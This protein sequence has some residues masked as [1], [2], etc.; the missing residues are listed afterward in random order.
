[1]T[2]LVGA[3]LAWRLERNNSALSL[4]EAQQGV[5]YLRSVVP[6]IVG[7]SEV[8]ARI[9]D[10][11][12]SGIAIDAPLVVNNDQ[13]MRA[14]EQALNQVYRAKY[15]GCHPTNLTLYPQREISL[16][17]EQ[18]QRQGY[19]HLV[20]DYWQIECYPHPA[21]IEWFQLDLRIAYKRGSVDQRKE[22]QRRLVKFLRQWIAK[23]KL[24]VDESVEY[25]FEPSRIA[26]LRGNSLKVNED[27]LDAVICGLI[28]GC[29]HYQTPHHCFGSLKDG[30]IWVPKEPL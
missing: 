9:I 16:L 20:T 14:C 10:W 3:D 12:P 26:S 6:A 18:L 2:L 11:Q 17:S 13:G 1:M 30:Y 29:Y 21:L 8:L 15:A 23:G 19:H 28:A 22:G 4:V 24:I 5:L 25:L 27:A 7:A